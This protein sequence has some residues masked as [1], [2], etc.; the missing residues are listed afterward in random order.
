MTK[1]SIRESIASNSEHIKARYRARWTWSLKCIR[2]LLRQG[3]AFCG[4]DEKKDSPNRG[5]F[6]ELLAWLSGFSTVGSKF[7]SIV[8]QDRMVSTGDNGIRLVRASKE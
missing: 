5:N 4:H 3:L 8:H 6:H 7:V 2:Y 1:T